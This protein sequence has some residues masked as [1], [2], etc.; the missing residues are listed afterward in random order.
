MQAGGTAAPVAAAAAAARCRPDMARLAWPAGDAKSACNIA[1]RRPR[2]AALGGCD[3]RPVLDSDHDAAEA[4]FGVQRD[5]RYRDAVRLELPGHMEL[6]PARRAQHGGPALSWLRRVSGAE[7]AG[8]LH[9]PFA[10][11]LDNF[12]SVS[13]LAGR[14]VPKSL[15]ARRQIKLSVRCP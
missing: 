4:S 10:E 14:C 12:A 9:G 3:Q 15:F 11:R 13:L 1:A 6:V 8:S 2:A 7:S 5:L